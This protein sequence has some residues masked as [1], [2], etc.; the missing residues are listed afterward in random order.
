[1]LDDTQVNT[2]P[3]YDEEG[4]LIETIEIDD[5]YPVEPPSE[6]EHD[7]SYYLG[8]VGDLAEEIAEEENTDATEEAILLASEK[9]NEARL[10][11]IDKLTSILEKGEVT[12]ED[13]A[14]LT[15]IIFNY[16]ES[17]EDVK[18]KIEE[19]SQGLNDGVEIS[20][21]DRL[22]Q[23]EQGMES[24]TI[25]GLIEILSDFGRKGWIYKDDNNNVLI[26]GTAIPELTIVAQKLNLIATS[27]SDESN[28]QLT[29]EFI[30][31][32]VQSTGA[33]TKV[34]PWYYLSTSSTE[35]VG[36]TWR[37]DL[38]TLAEQEGKF[39]WYKLVTTK[40]ND[41]IEESEPM[42]LTGMDGQDGADG[43][44]GT[45]VNIMGSY[46][47]YNDLIMAHPTGNN[48]GDAYTVEETGHL[49]VW[50]GDAFQDVGKIQGDS[51]YL[52]IKYS[53]DGKTFTGND[54]EDVGSWMGVLVDN[55]EEDSMKFTDYKWNKVQGQQ[56]IQGIQG[57][58]GE[59]GI[60]GIP[61]TNGKTSYFHIK[62]S[63][64][65]NP[66]LSSQLLET[67]STYIGTYVDFSPKDSTNPSDYTWSRFEG[68]QGE[69]GSQG[70]PGINGSNGQTSYLHIKYSN[71]NGNTF[72]SN[73]GETVG[74]YIGQYVDFIK[75]DSTNPADY[76]WARILGNQGPQGIPGVDGIT[77]YTWI[78]YADT[79]TGSG[80][81][82]DPT[83]KKYIGFAYNKTTP[84]ESSFPSDYIWS[85]I[86]GDKGDTGVPGTPGADGITYYTWIKYSAYADG[87]YMSDTPNSFTEYIGIATNKT[88]PVESTD[89]TQYTWSKFKGDKGDDGAQGVPGID[90]VTY[91]TWIRYADTP[92]G[93][94]MSNDPTGKEYIG[95]AYNKT[96]PTESS[97]P[98]DYK[99]S[100]I[101]G[102]KGDTGVPGTPG[103]DGKTYYTWIKYSAYSDGSYMT[104]IPYSDTKYIGIAINKTTPYESN[105]KT[106]YT[107]S[108]FKGDKGDTGAP[109]QDGIDGSDGTSVESV[110]VQFAKSMSTTT[111]PTSGW[112]T[113]MP[114]YE[115]GYY[116]WRRV[117]VKY[118][119][120]SSYVYGTPTV[121]TSWTANS[122]TR[123]MLEVLKD[124]INLMATDGATTGTIT[125]TPYMISLIAG[126]D[127]VLKGN[128]IKITGDTTIEGLFSANGLFKILTDGSVE[129][130]TL[131][132]NKEISTETLTVTTINN[133]KY[134]QCLDESIIVFLDNSGSTTTSSEVFENDA[135]FKTLSDLKEVAPRNL[136]GYTL[137]IR[138]KST[139][140]GNL[141]FDFFNNGNVQFEL[142]GYNVRGY[143]HFYGISMRYGI[144]GTRRTTAGSGTGSIIPNIGKHFDGYRYTMLCSNTHMM[145]YDL[146]I[147]KGKATDYSNS[148]IC[149]MEHSTAYIKNIMAVNNP[150]HLVR[151]NSLSHVYVA[152]SSGTTTSNTFSA[153]SGSIQHLNDTTQAGR[154]G[155]SSVCYTNGNAQIFRE[156]VKF[157]STGI[158][159]NND[160]SSTETTT[161]TTTITS[162][163]G[164]TYRKTV[165]N[166]W[167]G[168]GTVRQGTWGY[169]NCVGCWFF[170]S[171]ISNYKGK[172]VS[173]IVITITRSSGGYSSAVG[174][175]LRLH[176]HSSRPSGAPSFVSTSTFNKTLSL[177]TGTSGSIT[178][179]DSAT[180]N[181]ILS[182]KGFGLDPGSYSN[183]NYAVCSGTM[184]VKITYTE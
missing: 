3:E 128:Q 20:L 122:E 83:G 12:G 171:K 11:V 137:I 7:D 131:N 136:N 129:A 34:T 172:N 32:V 175:K 80:I 86:K 88:S 30:Q 97:F 4:N 120:T 84:T 176:N 78:K 115:K 181:A 101:K 31:M 77:Y 158:T 9:F 55:K 166:N 124:K 163:S 130:D 28:L 173:K 59:Q 154:S 39:L 41:T 114:S 106:D 145:I 29:P 140:Y 160:S 110:I 56:G 125:L 27:G 16:T 92:T 153:V 76:K 100:L 141:I 81:S 183:S 14:E 65:P 103:A 149:I 99:W 60:P 112:S 17:Y 47:T 117:G 35:L 96:T 19:S 132:V 5:I 116:L 104:D 70:I 22:A 45:S 93:G 38:P 40:G 142:D 21:E 33:I 89:K 87:S 147:Y 148:G 43:K 182:A 6:V 109:G 51:S 85:L 121:D 36:G 138:L 157:S 184:K 91:Y 180:I 1:M 75:E 58:K 164:D 50:N 151:T 108:Q 177:A 118:S 161:Q 150:H 68:L 62:Y 74:N 127:L 156:G 155:S 90:G 107:W 82:N 66:T 48:R 133:D 179:T 26:D 23:L 69:T 144:Y 174:L 8:E 152:S 143:V 73:N 159:G 111:P 71:D 44:D 79:A 126:S 52:H 167:K 54:G 72:T 102:D 165:Y 119:N 94:G 146:K 53:N 57:E 67:P 25:D 64:V 139:Y 162:T 2:T 10:S 63:S 49:W 61:G 113:T 15:D 95:F 24:I 42:R 134:P 170:G 123:A 37:E 18:N 178:I 98:S 13:N 168:D 169:G 135:V 46:P 105:I